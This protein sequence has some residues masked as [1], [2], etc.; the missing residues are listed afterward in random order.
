MKYYFNVYKRLLKINFSEL[1][2]YRA[3]FINS[4]ISSLGWGFFQM[5]WVYLLT[6]KIKSAYGW[7]RDE[8]VILAASYIL[9][10]GI[11][12]MFFSR[13][14]DNLSRIINYGQLD[15]Y[16][17][18]PID[19]QLLLTCWQINYSQ[20]IRLFIGSYFITSTL[21]QMRYYPSVT[22]VIGFA[23]LLIFGIILMYAIWFVVATLLIWNPQLSNLIDFLYN[24]TGM[25]RYPPS[26]VKEFKSIVLLFFI[27]L[28]LTVAVPVKAMINKVLLGDIVQL[29]IFSIFLL[30]ISRQFW[31]FALRYY[32]SAS[33]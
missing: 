31:H 10:M 9:F 18:K 20:I 14:L 28:M 25:S 2:A 6:A 12:H 16:L 33:S 23:T 27:P 30:Y 24:I 32:A 11:F 29:L 5:V 21:I 8:L 1:I 17:L 3:G 19:S 15:G 7:N 22:N 4:I 26:M 13:N